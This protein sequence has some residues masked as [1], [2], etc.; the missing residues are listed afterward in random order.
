[1]TNVEAAL[2]AA[3]ELGIKL[4]I[5]NG[6]TIWEGS[7]VY[8]HQKAI[9]RIRTSIQL[10]SESGSDCGC[11][12]IADVSIAFPDGSKKR[13]DIS[14]FCVEPPEDEEIRIIPEAVIEVISK[15]YEKKDTEIGAPFYLSQG[16]KDV[17]LFDPYKGS[18]SHLRHDSRRDLA[19]P[20]HIELECGCSCTV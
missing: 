19:S 5:V 11:I 14:I 8:K 16:V 3:E 7:P 10:A 4:E 13:P 9:D 18:V 6:L 1:M 15:D 20:V 17:I 2:E 12:H